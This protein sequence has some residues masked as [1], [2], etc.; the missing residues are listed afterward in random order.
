MS[1]R[2][3][4]EPYWH[5]V[6]RCEDVAN[7]PVGVRLLDQA[8]VVYRSGGEVVALV[9]SCVHRGAALSLGRLEGE[10][11]E[12]PYHGFLYDRDGRCVR[13]PS[14]QAGQPIPEKARVA[15]YPTQERYG[16]IWVALAEPG[17][18]IFDF[19]EY[20]SSE[21]RNVLLG[22]FVWEAPAQRV[23]ESHL[24]RTHF[25]RASDEVSTTA[26]SGE[27]LC[28]SDVR[29]PNF[30]LTH[31][32]IP[33]PTQL[34]VRYTTRVSLPLSAHTR[35][36]RIEDGVES[37]DAYAFGLAVSPTSEGSCR[38]YAWLSR[39]YALEMPDSEFI[40][41][42]ERFLA[43]ERPLMES[44]RPELLVPSER[45][46]LPGEQSCVEYRSRLVAL[47]LA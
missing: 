6:L 2:S 45:Y 34:D 20:E 36:T 7:G 39:N 31:Q 19:P 8:L 38:F 9:D 5:P 18:D 43:G 17:G 25:G 40:F 16:L 10:L 4:L 33:D 30:G 21:S 13:I 22:P 35:K 26:R 28:V 46:A 32:P 29:E 14:M 44:R 37:R 3:V 23:I 27:L 41:L 42:M 15:K 47:G 11:L 1:F 24:D 12:C